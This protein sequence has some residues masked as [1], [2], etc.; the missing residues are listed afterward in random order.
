MCRSRS[1]ERETRQTGTEEEKQIR[2]EKRNPYRRRRGADPPV[3][4]RAVSLRIRLGSD[5]KEKMLGRQSRSFASEQ[6]KEWD[7][8]AAPLSLSLPLLH[9][10]LVNLSQHRLKLTAFFPPSP[11]A[12][13]P[14]R[15]DHLARQ[16][17]PLPL[18]PARTDKPELEAVLLVPE[19]FLVDCVGE[20]REGGRG[21]TEVGAE[22]RGERCWDQGR[23]K[24]PLDPVSQRVV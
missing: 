22:G 14:F 18:T 11:S 2:M 15:T 20:D 3:E 21:Q 6:M 1:Y 12:L 4:K 17:L 23:R 10:L 5:E 9:L 19:E 7:V 16:R 24:V 8:P 13:Q